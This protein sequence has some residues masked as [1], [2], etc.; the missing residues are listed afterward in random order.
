MLHKPRFIDIA[1]GAIL[2]LCCAAP[3]LAA[4]TKPSRPGPS[5]KVFGIVTA[6][7]D[8]DIT[9]KTEG[10]DE[11]KRYLLAPAGG[12]PSADLKTALKMVFP[13]NLV[14]FQ[15]QDGQEP[16]LTGI[17][18]MH[19]KTR[20]GMTTGT[21]VAVDSKATM[22]NFDVKPSGRG[23]TERYVPRW[24]VKAKS[25]DKNLVQIINGLNV[26]DKVKISWTYDERK[27]AVQI[28]VTSKAKPATP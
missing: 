22:P 27:R 26:G 16:V 4:D 12:A 17:L 23:H 7:S 25:M 21:I 9:I 10:E 19:S 8:K 13:T 24:D 2:V 15:A 1:A 5:A 6:R 3:S 14:V 20:Q 28:V 11:A 18:A